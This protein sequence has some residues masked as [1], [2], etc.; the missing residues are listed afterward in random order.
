MGTLF[1]LTLMATLSPDAGGAQEKHIKC[2]AWKMSAGQTQSQAWP[3]AV[4]GGVT[5][6]PFPWGVPA[7]PAPDANMLFASCL[8]GGLPW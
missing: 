2:R 3:L 6:P 7:S 1:L 8:E 4:K 5:G